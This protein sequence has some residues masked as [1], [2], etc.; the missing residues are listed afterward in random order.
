MGWMEDIFNTAETWISRSD[1]KRRGF[2]PSEKSVAFEDV[3]TRLHLWCSLV[4]GRSWIM[5][6]GES[7]PATDGERLFFPPRL[8]IFE[9]RTLNAKAY[10]LISCSLLGYDESNFPELVR[11]RIEFQSAQRTLADSDET[12]LSKILFQRSPVTLIKNE[13]TWRHNSFRSLAN[14]WVVRQ[15]PKQTHSLGL[16]QSQ[17]SKNTDSR[18][19]FKKK[20]RE[21]IQIINDM[22]ALE[23]ENPLVHS[24]EKLHTTDDYN[25]GQKKQNGDDELSDQENSL[26]DLDLRQVI[27]TRQETKALLKGDYVMDLE[28]A[29]SAQLSSAAPGRYWYDEWD[30]AKAVYHPAWCTLFE[31]RPERSKNPELAGV[32]ERIRRQNKARIDQMSRY[33]YYFFQSPRWKPRQSEGSELDIDSLIDLMSIPLEKRPEKL[34]VYLNR[35]KALNELAVILLFDRSLSSDSWIQ[36][37]RV[38]DII[39][40]S[41]IVAGEAL[42]KFPLPVQVAA[43]SSQTRNKVQYDIL[44]DFNESWEVGQWRIA[45]VEPTGYTRIGPALR[46]ATQLINKKKTRHKWILILSDSKPTDFDKYEG[47]YG[48]QDV[49]KATREARPLHIGIRCLCIEKDNRVELSEMFGHRGYE[50]LSRLEDLPEALGRLMRSLMQIAR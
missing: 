9:E 38:L 47:R 19:K 49:K 40:E 27:R 31:T 32:V 6:E 39:K 28:V 45:S 24:F 25:G 15:L 8:E 13:W 5:Q 16:G 22:D 43:F 17:E 44:K 48:I 11:W 23:N 21:N 4:S 33:F 36:N 2:I 12:A 14:L 42:K 20:A 37:R 30:E 35:Q 7:W 46:H 18:A 1:K 41:L 34:N 29:V 26:E 3:K 10:F 50:N